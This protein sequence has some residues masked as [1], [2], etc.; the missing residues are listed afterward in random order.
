MPRAHEFTAKVKV[1]AF[2]RANGRCEGCHA[3]LVARPEYDHQ[4]PVAL[5][6][7]SSLENCVV[8]CRK[9]HGAKTAKADVPRIAK[10]KRQERKAAVRKKSTMPGSRDDKWK[11]KING[12]NE[13]R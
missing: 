8:L 5:G 7:E 11:R 6:G 3:Y 10:A 1:E 12:R 9:C 2:Q 4:I 13:L